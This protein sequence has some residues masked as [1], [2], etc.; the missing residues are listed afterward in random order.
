[1]PIITALANQKGGVGKTS[2]TCNLAASLAKAGR[3]VLALDL[4]PQ[5]NTSTTLDAKGEFDMYDVMRSDQPGVITD[6]IVDSTWP[7][8]SAVPGSK[9]L[10]LLEVESIMTPEHRLKNAMWQAG[11]LEEF[12]DILIDL[13]PSLGRLTLNGLIVADRVVIVT[14]LE[15]YSIAG[16]GE[17]IE[18]LTAVR[19]NPQLNPTLRLAGIVVNKA[20][21]NTI[22]H[23]AGLHEL[24]NAFGGDVVR[25]PYLQQSTVVASAAS[26]HKPVSVMRGAKAAEI[27]ADY[28]RHARWLIDEAA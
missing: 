3:R 16:V 13:P 15:T 27:A 19:R 10:A 14:E 24:K 2:A 20:R 25:S 28:A 26:A 12:D 8:I 22:E 21:L 5:A 17:F 18:T 9:R 11:G 7:G 1:M 23:Q 4:D 6:A